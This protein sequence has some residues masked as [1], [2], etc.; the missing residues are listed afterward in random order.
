M[1]VKLF[2]HTDLDGIGCA[3]VGKIAFHD[4]D[5]TYCNYDDVNDIIKTFILTKEYKNYDYIYI[6]D[7]SVN[8]EV[9][10][11][12]TNTHPDYFKEGY[13]L[14]EMIQLLDH[15][16]T[17]EWLNKYFW[18]TVA[19]EFEGEKTSGTRM[20][21][22]LLMDGEYLQ[23]SS[24]W[25]WD[26][27][28]NLFEFVENVRKYDTWLWKTKYN[29]DEPKKWNDL[30]F[31]MGREDFVKNMVRKIRINHDFYLSES[32][33][34]MLKYKQTEIDKYIDR[35]SKE[36]IKKDIQ[37]YKAG[38]IFAEQYH[39]E[40]GNVLAT[41]NPDL[42]FIVIINPSQSVSYRGIKDTIDLGAIAKIYGGGGHPQ[43]AGSPISEEIREQVINMIF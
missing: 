15:H 34:N 32:E 16:P 27:C 10:E 6:T 7:I 37:G 18:C 20:F 40:L 35:K 26:R 31:I 29:N 39:S 4:I 23:K 17:A 36:I 11:L 9:A 12:I 3:V 22:E 14:G 24:A 30:L 8:E 21:Y 43:A 41:N 38:V 13:N 25:E 33:L 5:I 28:S 1:K 2:T 19:V 42:D